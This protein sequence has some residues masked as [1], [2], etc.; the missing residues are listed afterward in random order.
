[1]NFHLTDE[2]DVK[3]I[4]RVFSFSNW[5]I[6]TPAGQSASFKGECKFD[7]DVMV[8]SLTRHTHRWGKDYTVWF[9]GG[10]R[11]GSHIWTST[12]FQEDVNYAFDSPFVMKQGEGFRFQCDFAN[13]E[14]HTLRFGVNATDEMCILFGQYW[15]AHDGQAL[16]PQSCNM[17]IL[18]DDG[19]ARSTKDAGFR[20]PTPAEVSAC[21]DSGALDGECA[22]CACNGC[23][24]VIA[25]CVSDEHC[26]AMLQCV[27]ASGCSGQDCAASCQ[28]VF[29]EHSS[30]LGMLIQL[31]G[32]MSSGCGDV[33]AFGAGNGGVMEQ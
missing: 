3:H 10:E 8:S 2:E 16:G 27:Q 5:T 23:G 17:T 24:G 32:C 29:D 26:N 12:D 7:Q 28:E 15:E 6:D 4:A 31:G 21:M 9:A 22:D 25:D 1:V 13:T 19:I 20:P 11:D 33:C 30:G 14:A 18:G